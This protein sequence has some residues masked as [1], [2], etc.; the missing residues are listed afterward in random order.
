VEIMSSLHERLEAAGLQLSAEQLA[1]VRR[2]R[3]EAHPQL[4]DAAEF[5]ARLRR[6]VE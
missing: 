5:Q 3:S 1:E 6:L 4:I 2:R